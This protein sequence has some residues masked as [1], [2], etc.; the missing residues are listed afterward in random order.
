MDGQVVESI[1]KTD[2]GLRV[3]DLDD[4]TVA[5]LLAWRL[6]QEQEREMAAEA[7]R[8]SGRAFTMEDG[9][10]LS[11]DYVYRLSWKMQVKAK[12]PQIAFHSLG[13]EHASQVLEPDV[14]IGAVSKRLGH[15]SIG[16]TSDLYSH[17]IGDASREAAAKTSSLVPRTPRAQQVH[18]SEASSETTKAPAP[19][20]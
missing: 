13:H 15:A 16:I 1:P 18:N 4:S 14:P 5:A 12:V 3:I 11:P 9:R 10:A 20:R 6:S 8:K 17:L 7:W 19:L 2:S